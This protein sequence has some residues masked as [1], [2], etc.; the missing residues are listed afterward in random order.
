[1]LS[2]D[3][4]QKSLHIPEREQIGG[5]NKIGKNANVS[6]KFKSVHVGG[7]G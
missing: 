6:Q 3:F 7:A 5:E 4:T 1:M 2:V